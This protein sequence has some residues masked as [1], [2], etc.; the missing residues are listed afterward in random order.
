M[1]IGPL[2][3][4]FECKTFCLTLRTQVVVSFVTLSSH[5]PLYDLNTISTY[6]QFCCCKMYIPAFNHQVSKTCKYFAV[7]DDIGGSHSVN[8][9][10]SFYRVCRVSAKFGS[11]GLM[12]CQS[13]TNQKHLTQ[14]IF[15]SVHHLITPLMSVLF[16]SRMMEHKHVGS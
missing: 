13:T 7:F 14:L 8:S 12:V 10:K 15:R 6:V 1:M 11:H 2:I 9:H 5:N 3:S 4:E 16:S